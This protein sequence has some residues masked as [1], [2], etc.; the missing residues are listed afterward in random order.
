MP[1]Y[2]LVFWVSLWL[3]PYQKDFDHWHHIVFIGHIEILEFWFTRHTW[4]EIFIGHWMNIYS[5]EVT[6]D[7]SENYFIFIFKKYFGYE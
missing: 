3:L 6:K 5:F 1:L 2:V 7:I 4:Y